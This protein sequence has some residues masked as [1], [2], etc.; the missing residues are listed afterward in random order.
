[1]NFKKKILP[2]LLCLV[3][4]FTLLPTAALAA[5]F[6]DTDGHWGKTAIDRWADA[7][8]LNGKGNGNFDPNANMTRAEFAQVLVNLMGYTETAANPFTDVAD[9]AWYADAILKLYAAGVM[10]GTG[11]T[12]AS[13]NA[14]ISREQVAVL[15]CRA[16]NIK[17]TGRGSLSGFG[18]GA[19]VSS[20]A[21][22]AVTALAERGMMNGVGNNTLA[23]LANINRASVA[24]LTSNM[25]A[26]YVTGNKEITGKVDG[27]VLV[28]AG[29]T[30]TVKDAELTAPIIVA[31]K[32]ANAKVTLTG[33]TKADEVI[34][35]AKNAGVTVD[36]DASVESITTDAANTT[37]TVSGAVDSIDVA[38]GADGAKIVANSGAK[39][40]SVTT[41][42]KDVKVTGT[43]EVARVTATA[44]SVDV[45]TPKTEVKNN[46]ADKVTAGNK[47]VGQGETQV[48]ETTGSSGGGGGGGGGGTV[49]PASHTLKVNVKND[50]NASGFKIT[51]NGAVVPAEG[52][53]VQAGTKFSVEL[54]GSNACTV[55][56]YY[57]GA[58]NTVAM[59]G[60]AC[61][62]GENERVYEFDMP[63]KDALLEI[64]ILSA[65]WGGDSSSGGSD[66]TTQDSTGT[67]NGGENL[68]QGATGTT[69]Y[70]GENNTPGDEGKGTG[71]GDDE[72]SGSGSGG[73][74]SGTGAGSGEDNTGDDSSV[75]SSGDEDSSD[76]G[77]DAEE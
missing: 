46:G 15:L 23:P 53:S 63:N 21:R 2:L 54:E 24:Q 67:C 5:D 33:A 6:S 57:D 26:E 66:N 32:A 16:L 75:A 68:A 7:G 47:E 77:T 49:T 59:N 20:W 14:P 3:M 55:V 42:A 37:V 61:S 4:M 56:L 43:G 48:V 9:D 11:A 60:T 65:C 12:T 13:P 73:V 25:I 72:S 39:I 50:A 36:K 1:M 58:G 76:T 64:T 30:V 10:S 35:A 27:I 29:A 38:K 41:A 52:I 28:A 31:P 74:A 69:C 45:S 18:D 17:P 40:D 44:G 71:T 22:D 8:I 19:Q 51:V 34:V 62:S 70:G